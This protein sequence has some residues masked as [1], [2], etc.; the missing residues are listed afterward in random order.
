MPEEQ[1]HQLGLVTDELASDV[2]QRQEYLQ[3]IANNL[4]ALLAIKAPEANCQRLTPT[5]EHRGRNRVIVGAIDTVATAGAAYLQTTKLYELGRFIFGGVAVT[6][7]PMVFE[8]A[9]KRTFRKTKK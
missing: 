9:T 1:P 8:D 6:L 2:L 3:S 5:Q 4:A 7:V